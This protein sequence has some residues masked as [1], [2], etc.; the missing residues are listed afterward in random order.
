MVEKGRWARVHRIELDPSER[1]PG[2]PEDTAT[3]PF[4]TWING[5]LVDDALIGAPAKL[6]TRTGRT[7]D[8]ILVEADPGYHHSFGSPP[9]P[10]QRAGDRARER[11]FGEVEL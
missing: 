9:P 11:L 8:G 3:V 7:V 6:R 2:I 1:A 4:E 5:W 10:L